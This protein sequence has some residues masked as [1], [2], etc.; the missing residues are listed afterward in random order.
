LSSFFC[1]GNRM[2]TYREKPEIGKTNSLLSHSMSDN[3]QWSCLTA[4]LFIV[5]SYFV[6]SAITRVT[7]NLGT[8]LDQMVCYGA[9]IIFVIIMIWGAYG[10]YRSNQNAAEERQNWKKGCKSAEL[11]ILNRYES[12]AYD[13]GY[14]YHTVPCRLELEMNSDQIA[15]SPNF[16]VVNVSVKENIFNR[17]KERHTVRI[18]YM[19]ETPLTFLLEDEL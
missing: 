7:S 19:P 15:F 8:K 11:T 12:G 1:Y 17:L 9:L 4:P 10:T 5:I 3:D 14:R 18:Y 16:T 13:D 2:G 6:L